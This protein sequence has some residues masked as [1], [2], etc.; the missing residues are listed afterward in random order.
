ME[1]SVV[2]S[3]YVIG[4]RRDT[5]TLRT[6]QAL[7][8]V[9]NLVT[10]SNGQSFETLEPITDFRQ[11]HDGSPAEARI[12]F[13]CRQVK[14]EIHAGRE[15][16]LK[17]KV[18]VY[19][20]SRPMSQAPSRNPSDTTLKE[21]EALKRFGAEEETLPAP[22]LIG[23][24]ETV[25][26]PDGL[27]PGGY[28]TY[29]MMTKLPGRTLYDLVYWSMP[30]EQRQKIQLAFLTSLKQVWALG[31]EPLDRALRNIMWDEETQICSIID[32]EMWQERTDSIVNEEKTLQSWGVARRPPPSDW[33]AEWILHH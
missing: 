9:E 22:T 33:F 15:A 16:V 30:I 14:P 21:L 26:G 4:Q 29:T 7:K 27:L 2:G 24:K 17:V 6:E 18:Q 25:Q 13:L 32:F 11:C 28:I 12:L 5:D 3:S 31:I 19:H 8:V 10:L 20:D 1:V 23:F